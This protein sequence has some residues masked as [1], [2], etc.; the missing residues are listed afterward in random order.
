MADGI[1]LSFLCALVVLCGCAPRPVLS[2]MQKG[3]RTQKR[4]PRFYGSRCVSISTQLGKAGKSALS[5][6]KR[7]VKQKK[8]QC[9][10]IYIYMRVCSYIAVIFQSA[11]RVRVLRVASLSSLPWVN[12]CR[13]HAKRDSNSG[14]KSKRKAMKIAQKRDEYFTENDEFY[15]MQV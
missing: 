11:G 15:Y 7:R 13:F 12:S 5:F 8:S 2:Y 10:Y 14:S 3:P 9:A 1:L 4:H 6:K